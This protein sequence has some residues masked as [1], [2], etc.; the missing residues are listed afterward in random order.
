MS[1]TTIAKGKGQHQ[2][3]TQL[4]VLRG[5]LASH[6]RRSGDVA[7]VR[8]L[9]R[10]GPTQPDGAVLSLA[11]VGLRAVLSGS[12]AGV[13]AARAD[14]HRLR[15]LLLV[16][17]QLAPPRQG[18]HRV[19]G[20]AVRS[21]SAEPGHRSRQQRRL[22]P[23]V[24]RD[25]GDP[26]AR[27]RAGGERRAGGGRSGGADADH[28]VPHRGRP[29][30]GRR[31]HPGRSP[32]RRQRPGPGQ[33]PERL[34]ERPQ[35]PA[36]AA[37][38]HHHRVSPSHAFDGGKPVRHDLSRAL[39]V[40]LVHHRRADLRRAQLD[41][42][43][44]GGASD[45]RRLAADLRPARRGHGQARRRARPRAARARGDRGLHPDRSLLGVR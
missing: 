7:A 44:R 39:L 17:G 45:P 28:D 21:R 13:R 34:R 27:H 37:G 22:S 3:D 31:R 10:R 15:V 41:P 12:G 42:F 18:L 40:L 8:E 16:F 35:D 9:S 24:F 20:E 1:S 25:A 4:S 26:R 6:P 2:H 33:Q 30:A 5:A 14:L 29:R 11:R 23:A 36:Q 43:R 19:D 32:L 38:R